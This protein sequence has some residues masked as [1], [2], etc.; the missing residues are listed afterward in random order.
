MEKAIVDFLKDQ[1]RMVIKLENVGEFKKKI[2][3]GIDTLNHIFLNCHAKKISF[4]SYDNMDFRING[5]DF[6]SFNIY[7]SSN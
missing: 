7:K 4:T 2:I 1:N 6:I 3:E 5:L